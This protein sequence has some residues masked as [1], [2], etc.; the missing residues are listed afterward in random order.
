[1][2]P[3]IRWLDDPQVFRVNRLD[4]HSDHPFYANEADCAAGA[5]SLRQSL[6]G[7]WQFAY[8]Q[9]AAQRPAQF[10]Q[11]DFDRSGFGEITVP[12]HIELSGYD[13]VH[14]INTMYPW[15]GHFFRRPTGSGLPG[16]QETGEFSGADY[17]PVGSYVRTFDLDP[18]L[19][20]KRVVIRFEGVEQAMYVWLNGQFIGY[21]EDSFTPS[22][23]DLT[24]AVRETGNLLAVEVHKRSTAAYLE[25]QDFFRF[26]GIFRSVSLLGLPR[27]HVEDLWVRPRVD[28]A[29]G[30]GDVRVTLR[31]SG[32]A[33]LVDL[34]VRDGR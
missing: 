4:A 15:E 2:Q 29:T 32:D 17:N 25:D 31:L 34:R 9:C 7:V 8:A 28:L 12:G 33:R 22:E 6:D 24:G 30:C 26:F 21:A 16:V 20:G 19:R 3:D 14:Y 10:Y 11:E 1:M 27:G 13:R 18:A 23:F 5:D